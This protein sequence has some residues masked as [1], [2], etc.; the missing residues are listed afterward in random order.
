MKNLSP[1]VAML[2]MTLLLVTGCAD[3]PDERL[4]EL[5][6]Q[7]LRQ[8]ASQNEQLAEQSK[9]IAEAS[10]HL[11]ENDSQARKEMIAAHATLQK[12]L[13]TERANIN[14]Q[15]SKIEQERRAIGQ[16]RGR[17]PIVAQ[18]IGA[19]GLTLACLLPLLLAGYIIYTLN[20]SNDDND[21]LSELLVLEITAEKPKLLPMAPRS[22]AVVEHKQSPREISD[23][24][25]EPDQPNE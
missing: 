14:Q 3:S 5:A 22:V 16:Q 19:V 15:L 23:E 25:D 17:D 10:R 2:M 13:Q 7:S 20:H 12:E 8:Q 11:V 6:E 1:G 4:A 18:T 21:A 9:Q 24:S